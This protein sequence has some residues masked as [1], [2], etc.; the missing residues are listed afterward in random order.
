MKRTNAI[1]E[2]RAHLGKTHG[3]YMH[4]EVY[5]YPHY[6][7]PTILR[8]LGFVHHKIHY[9]MEK[10]NEKELEKANEVFRGL[11]RKSH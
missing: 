1:E 3:T 8:E 9:R 5:D 6:D 4:D 2:L 10:D 11:K 7:D